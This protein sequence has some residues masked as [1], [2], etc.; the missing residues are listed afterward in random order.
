MFLERTEAQFLSSQFQGFPIPLTPNLSILQP[1][2]QTCR[3]FKD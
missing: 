1:N 3:M 2:P